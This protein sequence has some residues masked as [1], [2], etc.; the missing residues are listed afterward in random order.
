[1]PQLLSHTLPLHFATAGLTS[2]FFGQLLQ[3]R[4]FIADSLAD[5]ARMTA[6]QSARKEIRGHFDAGKFPVTE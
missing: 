6:I 1:M 4:S 3:R 2:L 5:N